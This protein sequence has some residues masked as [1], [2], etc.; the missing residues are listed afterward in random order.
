MGSEWYN[1]GKNGFNQLKNEK[2]AEGWVTVSME[3]FNKRFFE[4]NLINSLV[5]KY[6]LLS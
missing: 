6:L 1:G 2:F 3:F 4:T 5:V